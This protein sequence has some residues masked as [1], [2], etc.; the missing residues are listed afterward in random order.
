MLNGKAF[1]R[2]QTNIAI[3]EQNLKAVISF[4]ITL[5]SSVKLLMINEIL[6]LRVVD[7]KTLYNLV[8]ETNHQFSEH[9]KRLHCF[10]D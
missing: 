9:Y 1:A 6:P 5:F 7:N 2:R 10:N 8:T 4:L 3:T